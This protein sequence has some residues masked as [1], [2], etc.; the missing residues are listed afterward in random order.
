M[1]IIVIILLRFQS[2]S[3]E[4]WSILVMGEFRFVC[5]VGVVIRWVGKRLRFISKKLIKV[6][7]PMKNKNYKIYKNIEKKLRKF[8]IKDISYRPILIKNKGSEKIKESFK[9]EE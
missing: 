5:W 7:R 1:Y 2:K 9:K 3:G 4:L 8:K 6:C